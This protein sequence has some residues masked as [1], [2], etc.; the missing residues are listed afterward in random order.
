M[1]KLVFTNGCFDLIH[2]GHIQLLEQAKALGTYLIVGINSDNSVRSIKGP[3]RPLLGESERAEILRAMRAVDEVRIFDEQTPAKLIQEI[4][5]DVLVKGGDWPVTEIVGASF[6]QSYGGEVRSLPLKD[7]FSSTRLIENMKKDDGWQ[8]SKRSGVVAASLAQHQ[9][10]FEHL[11][12][13]PL[14]HVAEL[15]RELPELE[16]FGQALGPILAA[17]GR[18]GSLF[19]RLFSGF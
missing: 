6:V 4:R 17:L 3:D 14:Q 5:P 13:G 7:G 10:V 16:G 2:P 9:E 19:A 1:K 11:E 12:L 18:V 8:A 15:L